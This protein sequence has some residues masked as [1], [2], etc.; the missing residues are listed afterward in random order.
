VPVTDLAVHRRGDLVASTQ[1][2]AFWVLDA[3]GPLREL[4]DARLRQAVGARGASAHL[5]APRP[6]VR[7]R[8]RTAFGGEES[9]R[10]SAADPQY[11]PAGAVIDYWVAPGA[12]APAPVLALEVRDARG[13]L[14]RRFTSRGAGE[15]Q[16][17]VAANM[18]R[19]EVEAL[20]TPRLDAGPGR[21]G[22]CGTWRTRGRSTPR[23]RAAGGTARSPRRGATRCASR[24]RT[25]PAPPRGARSARSSSSPTRA[26][27]PTG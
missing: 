19:P 14:V 11:P 7:M 16:A 24:G 22:S 8:Y 21:T 5:F 15:R 20:G 2:R 9:S 23:R 1:G 17:P 26:R 3:L 12:A 4:A 27:W 10:A 18:R 13:A 6:A 25:R